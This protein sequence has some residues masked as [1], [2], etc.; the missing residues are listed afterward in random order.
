MAPGAMAGGS[1]CASGGGGCTLRWR[2]R[3]GQFDLH[4]PDSRDPQQGLADVGGDAGLLAG[5]K[6]RQRQ[7]QHGPLALMPHLADPA[8]IEQAA[9]AAR[10]LQGL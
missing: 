4:I 8:E 3:L 2:S 10:I 5:G 6:A 1:D 9:A 7:P